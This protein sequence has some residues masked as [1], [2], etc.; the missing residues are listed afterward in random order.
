MV[1]ARFIPTSHG[2]LRNFL[3]HAELADPDESDAEFLPSTPSKVWKNRAKV[4]Q[5]RKWTMT[6]YFMPK[7][8]QID[9]MLLIAYVKI[10]F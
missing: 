5:K 4:I 10:S 9:F 1:F 7:L 2:G 3:I 8:I 6:E